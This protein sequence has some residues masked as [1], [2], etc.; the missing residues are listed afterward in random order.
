MNGIY[1]K[2]HS[3]AQ[4]FYIPHS[5]L[6]SLEQIASWAEKTHENWAWFTGDNLCLVINLLAFKQGKVQH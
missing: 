4:I 1:I 5:D 2:T 6:A 3:I